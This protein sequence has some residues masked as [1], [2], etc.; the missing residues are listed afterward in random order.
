MRWLALIA[1]LP[2]PAWALDCSSAVTQADMVACAQSE[3]EAV[4]ADLNDA[5]RF[6]MRKAKGLDEFM[7]DQK[8][9]FVA[10]LRDA[11]RAWIPFRDK[12]CTAQAYKYSGGSMERLEYISCLTMMTER[13]T[14]DLY[15]WASDR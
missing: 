15:Y 5:Y 4:D 13:R 10:V 3:Y 7:P 1:L 2:A 8:P 6:A 11:Q 12:A 9:G 14:D